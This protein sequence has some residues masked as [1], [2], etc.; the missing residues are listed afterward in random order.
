MISHKHKTIFVHVPKVAGISIEKLFLDDLG[1]DYD[2]RSAL[3]LGV[4]L[5]KNIGPPRVSHLTAKEY[6]EQHYISQELYDDYFT[7][8]FV[9]NPYDRVY[10]FYKYLGYNSIISFE[11]FVLNYLEKLL[12]NSK[13]YY[14]L[15]PMYNYLYNSEKLLV[16]FVG[17]LEYI[18]KDIEKIY[19]E[20][21]LNKVSLTH[22]NKSEQIPL[23]THIKRNFRII[24]KYPQIIYKFNINKKSKN[25]EYT[26]QMKDKVFSLYE[27]D[28]LFFNYSK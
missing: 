24:N 15:Q 5:N 7:F 1:L 4:N 21:D 2:N 3:H 12:H 11:V 25:K 8:G 6:V 18:V 20:I 10:S 23:H 19:R 26:N 16:D 27:K 14:F 22:S 13:L 17:K 28:F 9:R